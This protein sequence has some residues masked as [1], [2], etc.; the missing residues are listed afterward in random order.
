MALVFNTEHES[1]FQMAAESSDSNGPL[2]VLHLSAPELQT[3]DYYISFHLYRTL[4]SSEMDTLLQDVKQ[5]MLAA[6]N[7]LNGADS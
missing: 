6:N 5:F 7:M 4:N 1:I 2:A 3:H